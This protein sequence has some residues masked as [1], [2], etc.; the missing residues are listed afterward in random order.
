MNNLRNH[1]PA[2]ITSA[3]RQCLVRACTVPG[4]DWYAVT[5]YPDGHVEQTSEVI[6]QAVIVL[7]INIISTV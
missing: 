1:L 3:L 6:R 4:R 7:K 2:H 5:V